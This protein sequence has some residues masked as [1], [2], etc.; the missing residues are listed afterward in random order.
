MNEFKLVNEY[1]F[2]RLGAKELS[3]NFRIIE[4]ERRLKCEPS[5]GYVHMIWIVKF[6]DGSIV[7]SVP[8]GTSEKVKLFL[9]DSINKENI[10]DTFFI[11]QLKDLADIEA[12]RIFGK[13]SCRYTASSIFVCNANTIAPANQNIKTIRITDNNFECCDDVNFPGHCLPDGVIYG[14]IENS[15]IVSLAYAHKTGIYQDLVAD[16][17]VDTSKEYRRKGYARECVN[18]VARH[19][20]NRSGESVYACSPD[21]IASVSTALA[22]G[23]KPFGE[24]FA[25][26]VIP[27]E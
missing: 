17:G 8:S 25:F 6:I 13:E 24:S 11:S 23:Y 22:A 5:Y 15:Q 26:T 18:S 12:K 4:T 7:A 10:Y 27:P 1:M 16:I 3:K 21:N 20:I 9:S 19:F 2:F 14:V